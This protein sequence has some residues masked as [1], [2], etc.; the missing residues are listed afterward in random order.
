[1]APL[2]R[3]LKRRAAPQLKGRRPG[4]AVVEFALIAPILLLIVMGMID[5]ARAWSAA[6]VIADAAREGARW[7]AVANNSTPDSVLLHV[8]QALQNGRLDASGLS[9]GCGTPPCLDVDDSGGGG[10]GATGQPSTVYLEYPYRFNLVGPFLRWTTGQ[11]TITLKSR[12]VMR[13]E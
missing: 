13:N 11:G 8:G 2:I 9:L 6:H 3:S 1:M 5:F 4:Q 10:G 7:S 12:I